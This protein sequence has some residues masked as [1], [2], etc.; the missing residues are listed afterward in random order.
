MTNNIY[1]SAYDMKEYCRF[2]LKRSALNKFAQREG[3]FLVNANSDEIA[4]TLSHV[5]MERKKI[6]SLREEAYQT[7]TTCSMSG[8]NVVGS[9]DFSLNGAYSEIKDGRGGIST[10]GYS[11]GSLRAE[12][13]ENGRVVYHGTLDYEKKRPG[14]IEFMDTDQGYSEFDL[15]ETEDGKWQIEVNGSKPNDGREVRKLFEQILKL[16]GEKTA[17]IQTLDIDDLTAKK[18]ILFFDKLMPFGLGDDWT[19]QDVKQLTFKRGKED[20]DDSD[21]ENEEVSD[22]DLMGIKQAILEGKNLR[23]A[24]FVKKFEQQGCMFT[25]MTFEYTHNS[26][27]KTVRMHAEFKGNPKIFEVSLVKY[28]ETVG[29]EAKLEAATISKEESLQLQSR[30]WNRAKEIFYEVKAEIEK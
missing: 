3:I 15:F 26:L 24:E 20:T 6:E 25:A 9:K 14:R 4:D 10:P 17:K 18:T 22:T 30:F 29:I 12:T 16:K 19:F 5:I 21:D 11:L 2:F 28:L 7:T 8:F 27:P 13:F 1:P 23:D